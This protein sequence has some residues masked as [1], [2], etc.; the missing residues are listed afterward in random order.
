MSHIQLNYAFLLFGSIFGEIH[1]ELLFLIQKVTISEKRAEILR[2]FVFLNMFENGQMLRKIRFCLN[3]VFDKIIKM[4]EILTK[5]C[6]SSQIEP[7]SQ[8]FVFCCFEVFLGK[9]TENFFFSQKSDYIR[10]EHWNTQ[11]VCFTEHVWNEANPEE[12]L[13]LFKQLFLIKPVK[14]RKF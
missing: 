11:K 3:I 4:R 12:N 8:T 13:D 6:F 10:N 9:F 7:Y 2:I 14:W 5:T 1:K